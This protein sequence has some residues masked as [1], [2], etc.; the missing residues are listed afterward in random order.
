MRPEAGLNPAA[1]ASSHSAHIASCVPASP[2]VWASLR[3]DTQGAVAAVSA[4]PRPRK[5]LRVLRPRQ[6]LTALLEALSP[7]QTLRAPQP[8]S[9]LRG[10]EL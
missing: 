8:P 2:P 6:A 3:T 4:G 5:E 1:P 9:S 7:R 10:P